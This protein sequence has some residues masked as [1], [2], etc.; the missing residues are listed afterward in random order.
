[1]VYCGLSTVDHG[2]IYTF[3]SDMKKLV[4]LL[5][6]VATGVS[7]KAQTLARYSSPDLSSATSVERGLSTVD[8]HTVSPLYRQV[9][10]APMHITKFSIPGEKK[11]KIGSTMTILGGALIVGGI[12]VFASG[13]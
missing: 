12:A 13:D 8:P 11:K 7:L 10:N 9:Y 3:I 2:L 6:L 1:M 5:F 4:T